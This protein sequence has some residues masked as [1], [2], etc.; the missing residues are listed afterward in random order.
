MKIIRPSKKSKQGDSEQ[1][2]SEDTFKGVRQGAGFQQTDY[3]ESNRYSKRKRQP[4]DSAAKKALSNKE[5]PSYSKPEVIADISNVSGTDIDIFDDDESWDKV[6]YSRTKPFDRDSKKKSSRDAEI[7]SADES[8]KKSTFKAQGSKPKRVKSKAQKQ[9]NTEYEEAA[10]LVNGKK[11]RRSELGSSGAGG[12][13]TKSALESII[14]PDKKEFNNILSRGLRILAIREHS[15]LEIT[16]KLLERF[17]E[18]DVLVHAVVDELV[19]LKYVS[20]ERFAES[21][22]RSRGNKGFGPVKIKAELK[23][24]GVSNNLIQD[25]LKENSG[26]WFYNAEKQYLKKYKSMPVEDYKTWTK[27]AKFLQSRGFTM[28]HI[29]CAVA[30]FENI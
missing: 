20:D 3:Q 7:N 1:E 17:E 22:V 24:K 19:K 6:E 12:S 2:R 26:H 10:P 15:V 27:R 28:E 23:G 11:R 4:K 13:G 14:D 9:D 5:N 30:P 29:H 21:Y 16:R 25:Y 8:T 18:K